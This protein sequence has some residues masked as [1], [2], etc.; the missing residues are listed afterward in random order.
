[1]L[2]AGHIQRPWWN[3][4]RHRCGQQYKWDK[5]F[6]QKDNRALASAMASHVSSRAGLVKR[7][8]QHLSRF[9]K[10]LAIR[11]YLD[12]CQQEGLSVTPES[13]GAFMADAR[14]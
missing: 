5:D 6:S 7:S 8:V 10:E 14:E 2:L 4:V 13:A 11:G 12:Y 1:M 3:S 9:Q